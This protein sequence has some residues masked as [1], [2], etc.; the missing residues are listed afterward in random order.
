MADLD[1]RVTELELRWMAQEDFLRELSHVVAD[2][3]RA[4]EGLTRRVE[5][6]ERALREVGAAVVQAPD[7]SPPPHY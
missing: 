2:H 1:E 5:R 6:L 3:A 4:L 7:D